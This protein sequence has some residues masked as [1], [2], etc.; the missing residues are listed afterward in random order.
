[1]KN[2]KQKTYEETR[3]KK[4]KTRRNLT[5]KPP[6]FTVTDRPNIKSH[7]GGAEFYPANG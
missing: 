4:G 7:A 6:I 3:R 5:K 2:K 1:M